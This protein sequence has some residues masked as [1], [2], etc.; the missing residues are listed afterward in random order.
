MSDARGHNSYIT[1]L[2]FHSPSELIGEVNMLNVVLRL[3]H[4]TNI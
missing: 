3:V 4:I 2:V 1:R